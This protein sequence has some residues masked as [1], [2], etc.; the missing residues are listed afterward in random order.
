VG[1]ELNSSLNLDV[2]CTT[3]ART[4]NFPFGFI[5]CK[6]IL[7]LFRYH[8]SFGIT[9]LA[10]SNATNKVKVRGSQN[11]LDSISATCFDI[12]GVLQECLLV[13]QEVFPLC[14][15]FIVI[16]ISTGGADKSLARPGMKQTRKH[17]RD[18]RDFNNIATRV[19]IKFFLS[20]LQGRAP[21][22]IHSILTETLA[23]F[24]PGRAKDSS[25][26]LY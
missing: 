3:H 21:K 4:H 18:A 22:E 10:S 26:P 17:V 15:H 2:A 1:Q 19:V 14:A 12:P 7:P 8:L 5:T 20:P 11:T 24:L 13:L 25:A 23:C 6:P 9:N 16:K